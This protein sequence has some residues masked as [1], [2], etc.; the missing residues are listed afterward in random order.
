MDFTQSA[1]STTATTPRIA[2][3]IAIAI[4]T[5]YSYIEELDRN[6]KD[7]NNKV[8][9]QTEHFFNSV[10]G[11][12]E[13]TVV[14]AYNSLKT[15]AIGKMSTEEENAKYRDVQNYLIALLIQKFP[16]ADFGHYCLPSLMRETKPTRSFGSWKLGFWIK[17]LA[18]W[19]GVK[20]F[21]KAEYAFNTSRQVS[22]VSTALTY[23]QQAL[24][25]QSY[26]HLQADEAFVDC[27]EI[28]VNASNDNYLYEQRKHV[29]IH[30]IQNNVYVTNGTL[31]LRNKATLASHLQQA[32]AWLNAECT[33]HEKN[34]GHIPTVNKH[35]EYKRVNTVATGD[36]VDG[37]KK[38]ASTSQDNIADS[39]NNGVTPT[40]EQFQEFIAKLEQGFKNFWLFAE[41]QM[42]TA[43]ADTLQDRAGKQNKTIGIPILMED[44]Q[45]NKTTYVP[46]KS[47]FFQVANT[48]EV[49]TQRDHDLKI[50]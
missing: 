17:C 6:C 2:Q 11:W 21:G 8:I 30:V 41:D 37:I 35:V 13:K 42:A 10:D 14:A 48:Q 7:Y 16:L 5:F 19:L 24:Q 26:M 40:N 22:I 43:V 23:V 20:L 31:K 33:E 46:G 36:E 39:A 12:G 27:L 18:H 28:V 34:K 50:N 32:L 3:R 25:Q 49:N 4:S 44:E 15:T 29:M 1:K 38:R 45:K 47:M 9:R